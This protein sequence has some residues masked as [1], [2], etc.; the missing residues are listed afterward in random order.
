V[1]AS[2]FDFA[3]AE[4]TALLAPLAAIV[5]TIEVEPRLHQVDEVARTA[6]GFV[7]MHKGLTAP[8]F[9]IRVRLRARDSVLSELVAL[10][11]AFGISEVLDHDGW[12]RFRHL[13]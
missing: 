6:D 5:K 7:K 12:V 3:S 13:P 8:T 4:V 1:D 11:S 9:R 2:A 10:E